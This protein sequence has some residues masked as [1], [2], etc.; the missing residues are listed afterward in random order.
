MDAD[1]VILSITLIIV[2]F[3]LGTCEVVSNI[4]GG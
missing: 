3:I 1:C 2:A 4:V